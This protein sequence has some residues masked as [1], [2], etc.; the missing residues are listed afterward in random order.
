MVSGSRSVIVANHT[1]DI[2]VFSLRDNKGR[3][4]LGQERSADTTLVSFE[5]NAAVT[6]PSRVIRLHLRPSKEEGDSNKVSLELKLN[7][8]TWGTVSTPHNIPWRLYILRVGILLG[9]TAVPC[10]PLHCRV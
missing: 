7:V 4:L 3:C 2:L 8:K 9:V 1:R 5:S 10:L 6:V